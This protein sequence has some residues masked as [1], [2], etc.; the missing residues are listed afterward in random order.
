MSIYFGKYFSLLYVM[1]IMVCLVGCVSQPNPEKNFFILTVPQAASDINNPARRTLL[2]GTASAASGYDNQGLVYR[3][4]PDKYQQDFYNDFMAP[5]ARLL[6]DMATQYLDARNTKLR[7]VRTPGLILADFGLET[8]LE[9]IYG[10]YT[11]EPPQA[12]FNIRFILNDLRGESP[13][14]VFDN[15]YQRKIPIMGK[16]P[17]SLVEA[18]NNGLVEVMAELNHEV[19]QSVR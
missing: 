1:A 4:G 18:L 3:V 17:A 12:V 15:N 10:D 16:G 6:M 19:E 2:V 7:V 14:V 11:V 8:Y 13:R 5:P 9:N